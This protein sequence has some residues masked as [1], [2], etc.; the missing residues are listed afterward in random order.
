[1]TATPPD[2][3]PKPQPDRDTGYAPSKWAFDGEV[4]RVFDDM[5]WRSIPGYAV[6]RQLCAGIAARHVRP[7]SIVVDL[8]CSRG[9]A[10]A[11]VMAAHKVGFPPASVEYVGAEI[12]PPMVAAA[13]ERFA[14]LPNVRIEEVDLRSSFPAVPASATSVVLSVLTLQFVPIEHR[15]RVVRRAAETLRD[16]GV[17]L[18]VEKILGGSSWADDLLVADYYDFK[19]GNGY[20]QEEIDRKRLA[21]EGVL[22]PQTEGAN[23]AMLLREGFR[24]VE[25]FW[26]H[27]NFCGWI[28]LR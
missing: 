18:V 21:L 19:R 22:V 17:M 4:T 27:L 15:A 14:H 13:R 26:R 6:M 23:V 28:A 20:T 2:A 12:S 25:C 16:G 24:E 8:G 5:L 9:G 11:E 7:G 3:E 10:L 1:M